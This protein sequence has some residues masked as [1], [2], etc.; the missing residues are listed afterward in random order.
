MSAMVWRYPQPRALTKVKVFPVPYKTSSFQEDV[1]VSC[2][3]EYWSE[4]RNCYLPF[5]H[6]KLSESEMCHLKLPEHNPKPVVAS[7]WR[8][9]ITTQQDDSE[10]TS[11]DVAISPR[12]LAACMRI[13]SYFNRSLIPRVTAAIYATK[14]EI[15]LHNSF[16]K[17]VDLVMPDCLKNYTPDF[18]Y[19]ESQRFLAFIIENLAAHV[20]HWE[21]ECFSLDISSAAKCSVLDYE[22]LTEQ[23]LIETF[24]WRAELAIADSLKCNVIMKPIEIK[25]GPSIGHAL[26]VATQ[27]WFKTKDVENN[28]IIM[29]RYVICNDT[30]VHIRFGQTDTDEDILLASRHFHSYSWRSQKKKQQLKVAVEENDWIW[31]K[32][33]RVLEDGVQ[34]IA[35]SSEKNMVMLVSVRSLSAT[36]KVITISGMIFMKLLLFFI[37]ISRL[38]FFWN[39][40]EF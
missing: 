17:T 19:P 5:A 26:A 24:S 36:Q 35:F 27:V 13:D 40:P 18:L 14:I 15:A 38:Q 33:F 6:F 1:T 31:S 34:T 10:D 28:F 20:S 30:N 21:H 8:V 32:S 2:E 37:S 16:E 22:F 23:S 29:T 39:F 4:I 7:A 11:N 12:A 9:S 3:L 25:F